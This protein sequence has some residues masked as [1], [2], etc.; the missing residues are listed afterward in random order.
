MSDH[1]GYSAGLDAPSTQ[2]GKAFYWSNARH[3]LILVSAPHLSIPEASDTAMVK[4]K[5]HLTCP[6]RI[7]WNESERDDLV[8]LAPFNLK[9]STVLIRPEPHGYV[10]RILLAG[11]ALDEGI[12]Q[13]LVDGMLLKKL[14]TLA[15]LLRRVIIGVRGG[16]PALQARASE[17][18]T[19]TQR[20]TR[21]DKLEDI[22]TSTFVL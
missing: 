22:L 5:R 10:I 7:V 1:T 2:N 20:H 16:I 4:R 15:V 21:S 8:F 19:I 13:I 9:T 6:L 3:E 12:N 18:L 11:G 17:I 14:S